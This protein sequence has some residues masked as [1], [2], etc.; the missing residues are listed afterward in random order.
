MWCGEDIVPAAPARQPRGLGRPCEDELK[1][2]KA[3]NA[4]L[5]EELEA[6]RELRGQLQQRVKELERQLEDR[7]QPHSGF[8]FRPYKKEP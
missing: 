2:K 5:R 4:R 8:E 7:R 3:E 1:E 6:E